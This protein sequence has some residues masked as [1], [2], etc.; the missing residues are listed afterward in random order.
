MKFFRSIKTLIL[1]F[2]IE[3]FKFLAE[4]RS[5]KSEETCEEDIEMED[6]LRT[7]EECM[8][9]DEEEGKTAENEVSSIEF[10]YRSH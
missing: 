10:Y 9:G 6:T 5:S 3:S 1:F 2:I 8:A 7:S 4:D